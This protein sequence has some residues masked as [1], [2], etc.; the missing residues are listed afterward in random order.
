MTLLLETLAS[1]RALY[2]LILAYF[3]DLTWYHSLFGHHAEPKGF[4]LFI[5]Q[6]KLV[7]T[8]EPLHLL[9]PLPRRSFAMVFLTWLFSVKILVKRLLPQ[10]GLFTPPKVV[11]SCSFIMSVHTTSFY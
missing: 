1:N 8:S 11:L 7:V 9:F 10:R 3:T 2:G 6:D 4:A 5:E